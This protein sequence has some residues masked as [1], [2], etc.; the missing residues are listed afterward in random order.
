MNYNQ[1][2][3][4]MQVTERTVVVGIDIAKHKHFARAL[5]FR[6]IEL[7][8][9]ISFSNTSSGFASLSYWITELKKKHDL[10]HVIVGMEPTGHYW[11][12]L[13]QWLRKQGMKQVLVNPAH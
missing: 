9:A 6:G 8:K 4:I 5:N 7:G 3:K 12:N 10:D 1:N 13:E 11:L 2:K